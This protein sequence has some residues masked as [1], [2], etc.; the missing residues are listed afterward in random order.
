MRERR[1]RH[2][3]FSDFMEVEDASDFFVSAETKGLS[4]MS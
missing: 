1:L 2:T 3:V 4:K